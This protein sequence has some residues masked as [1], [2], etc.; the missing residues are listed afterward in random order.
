MGL[1][2]KSLFGETP[3]GVC[4]E[5]LDAL[6][7]DYSRRDFQVRLWDGTT[8]GAE[9]QPRFTLVLKHPGALRAMFLSP[10]ELAL[11]EAYIDDD[12]DIEGDIEAAFDLADYFL[13]QER[14]RWQSLDLT[15]R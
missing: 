1:L 11:G 13:G 15:A 7:A 8:W 12:Y 9:T 5:F 3:T 14:S 4:A 2:E 6:L 10:S